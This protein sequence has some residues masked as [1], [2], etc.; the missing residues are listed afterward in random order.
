LAA[1]SATPAEQK[2][3]NGGSGGDVSSGG[4]GPD[5]SSVCGDSKV[6]PPRL[7]R[8]SRDELLN[9]LSDV[10]P[11]VQGYTP[12]L[13]ADGVSKH[14][15]DNDSSLLVVGKQTASELDRTADAVA[16]VVSGTALGT[17]LPCAQSAADA[18]CASEFL[19]KYGKRLFRRPL[20]EAESARYLGLFQ[21]ASSA[22]DFASGIRFVTRALI[23]SP[24]VVY[25]REVGVASGKAYQLSQHELAAALAYDFSGTAPSD[26]LLAQ[27]DAGQLATPTAREAAARALLSSDKGMATVEK[28]FNSWLGYGRTSSVTKPGVQEFEGLRDQMVAETRR[29]LGEVVVARGGG[30]DELLTASFTTPSASL[31]RFYGFPAPAADYEVVERP[32]GRGIGILAQA[33]LLAVLSTPEGSSP[34]RRGL[35]VME[36][37][38]CR[39]KPTVPADVPV[40]SAPQPGQLTTRQRYEQAHAAAG[41]CKGCHAHF[42]PIGFAFEHF[43]EV[44]RYREQDGGLP[45]DTAS[46]VPL[47]GTELF[48]FDGLEELAQGLAAEQLPYECATGYLSTYVFG[49]AEACLG[50]TRRGEFIAGQLGF[51]DYLASL[52]AEPHFAERRLP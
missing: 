24:H 37:L 20:S 33:S 51:I 26:E 15:F 13:S 52:A 31:A 43:D 38:L 28:F 42:D 41:S 17:L 49:S 3:G 29:F 22:T 2:N 16:T 35:M 40:L 5:P 14:G 50:E 46:Y 25:R 11:G 47:E 39:E 30:L 21:E 18:A 10:F 27:A 23:Q 12:V 4:S 9:T 36:R 8:L 32:A 1:C 6:G 45:I 7:R 48:R 34:T 44:G 19:A